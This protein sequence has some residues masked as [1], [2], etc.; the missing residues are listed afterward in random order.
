MDTVSFIRMADGTKEDYDL[1]APYAAEF[2]DGLPDRILDAVRAL[3]GPV[4]GF[5]LNRFTH[6]LQAATR[7]RRDQ[8]DV[9]YVVMTL[10]H[11]IGDALAPFTHSEMI[12]AV[13]RPFVRPEIEWIA[14]HHGLF[15]TYYYA[16]HQGGDRFAREIHRNHEW[17][18]ACVEFCALYDQESFDP[19]Y[20][21]DPLSSFEPLVHEVFGTPR[22][23]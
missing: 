23:L 1:L 18:A 11:D 10:V 19:D 3:D 12:G 5:R 15:Q 16:H 17:Y 21:H 4:E 2:S 14:R 20:R 8:R 13:L 6:S 7:T 22:Y 9:E